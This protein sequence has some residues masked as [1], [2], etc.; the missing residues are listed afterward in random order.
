MLRPG[1]IADRLLP[2]VEYGYTDPRS[3]FDEC[4]YVSEFLSRKHTLIAEIFAAGERSFPVRLIVRRP[5][6]TVADRDDRSDSDCHHDCEQGCT[7]QESRHGT[8]PIQRRPHSMVSMWVHIQRGREAS[9][10]AGS[11]PA[12]G[13]PDYAGAARVGSRENR[14]TFHDPHGLPSFPCRPWGRGKLSS[15]A[16]FCRKTLTFPPPRSR[17]KIPWCF[18][19][20]LATPRPRAG[21]SGDTGSPERS[22]PAPAGWPLRSPRRH[23]ACRNSRGRSSGRLRSPSGSR[24]RTTPTPTRRPRRWCST[25]PPTSGSAGR[26]PERRRRRPPRSPIAPRPT[27]STGFASEQW[28]RRAGLAAARG[29]TSACWSMP[30]DRGSPAA[31]GRAPTARSSA[32]TPPPTIP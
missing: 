14:S 30:P 8:G 10:E 21:L 27:A 4:S 6:P 28:T 23:R 18:R 26:R 12:N 17:S 29:P 32:V 25:F 16:G 24:S 3:R 19:H 5:Q 7:E 9:P 20:T 1:G 15:F 11:L 2:A 31:S 22:R 13:L